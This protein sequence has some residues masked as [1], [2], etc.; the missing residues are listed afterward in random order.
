MLRVTTTLVKLQK[1]ATVSTWKFGR[2]DNGW[3][4]GKSTVTG[5]KL[6]FK[7]ADKMQACI[8][9]YMTDYGYSYPVEQLSLFA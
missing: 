3:F 1:G 9:R 4:A 7:T 6:F 5:K 2:L 8:D